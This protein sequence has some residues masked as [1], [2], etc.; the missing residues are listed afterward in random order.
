MPAPAIL[1]QRIDLASAGQTLLE[2]RWPVAVAVLASTLLLGLLPDRIRLLP[3]GL[4]WVLGLIATMPIIAVGLNGARR[5]YWLR[6]ERAV[7]LFLFVLAAPAMVINLTNVVTVMV[8]RP[9]DISGIQLLSSSIG[10]WITNV[11]IF[12]LLYWQI[13]RGGPERRLNHASTMPD[14]LF[15]Q[16]SAPRED[17]SPDWRPTFVDY[18]YLAYSTATAFSTTDAMPLTPRSKLLMMLESSFSLMTVVVVASRA[19]NILGS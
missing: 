7:I 6:V 2:P 15:P 1:P 10:V 11:I 14:W 4:S 18:L 3:P 8:E 17:V 12:A 13:D 19:I 16:E 5:P 9:A